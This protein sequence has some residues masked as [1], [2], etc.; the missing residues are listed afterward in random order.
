MD[1]ITEDDTEGNKEI[2]LKKNDENGKS[3][4]FLSKNE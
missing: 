2:I 1:F 3:I 4:I